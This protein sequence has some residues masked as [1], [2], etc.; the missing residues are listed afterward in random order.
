MYVKKINGVDTQYLSFIITEG[1]EYIEVHRHVQL[2]LKGCIPV[3]IAG[4]GSFNFYERSFI[5]GGPCSCPESP[6]QKVQH[7]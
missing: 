7:N 2:K 1:Q 4:H 5:V 3:I 6:H